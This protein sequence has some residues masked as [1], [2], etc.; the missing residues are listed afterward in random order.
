MQKE[1]INL[2][3]KRLMYSFFDKWNLSFVGDVFDEP[4][5]N[6]PKHLL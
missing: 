4:S 3:A 5:T 6:V 1:Y 2:D